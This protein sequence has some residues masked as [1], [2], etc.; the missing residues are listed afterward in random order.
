M[1]QNNTFS[2][3]AVAIPS[4]ETKYSVIRWGWNGLNRTDK[5]DT[6]NIT[7]CDGVTV[8]PPCIIPAVEPK[9]LCH[10]SEPISAFGFGENLLVIYRDAG[11]I[12]IDYRSIDGA[13]YGGEL[14]SAFGDERDFRERTAVQFN[15]ATNTTNIINAEFDR[16]ILIFPDAYSMPFKPT[17]DFA[18]AF[19]GTSY[20]GLKCTV[21]YGSRVFGVDDNLVYA[22]A[23]NDY[24][25]WEL[26]TATDFS[27]GNAWASMSQAN[28][29]A[30]GVFTA[31]SSHDNHVVL[32][33]KDF[34]QLVY[35]DE[36][37]FRIIDVGSYGCDNPYAVA[38]LNGI[39]YFAS[40][41]ALYRYAGSTPRNISDELELDSLRGAVV[42]AYKDSVYLFVGNELFVLKA[43]VWASLGLQKN[44]IKQ[45]ATLDFGIVALRENGDID[46]I[47]WDISDIDSEGDND[48]YAPDYRSDWWFETD[49]MALG[50]LDVRRVKKVSVL[51][52]LEKDAEISVYLLRDGEK[53]DE[54]SSMKIGSISGG[55]LKMLRVLTRQ[56]SA[57]MHRLRICGSGYA[58]IYAAELKISW[59]GDVYAEG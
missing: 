50:K 13:V 59:G 54:S 43:G 44:R 55:G 16:R 48:T 8:E 45:L 3:G 29:R 14:G 7:A 25:D 57:Y 33:K 1:A 42:G 21:V 47:E 34:M 46:L 6:G 38:E 27:S 52:E 15:V 11:K 22:S 20:P 28:V 26:D 9:T 31:I 51:C 40:S 19:L 39:L 5:I 41:D 4:G 36:N 35:G 49:F 24:A 56:F 18:P 12:K 53:F 30:D 17:S 32:F 23:Y 37:P 2:Y 58:K 10:Y